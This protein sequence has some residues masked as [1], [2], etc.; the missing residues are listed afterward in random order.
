M[1]APAFTH[2]EEGTPESVWLT[3][4]GWDECRVTDAAELLEGHDKVVVASA[5]PDDETLAIG[6]LLADLARD[7]ASIHVI[8]ATDGEASHPD[9]TTWTS[10]ML[11]AARRREVESAVALLA[12][13]ARVTHLGL[14]DGRLREAGAVLC[15]RLAAELT[16]STLL[17]APWTDD[18]HP[19]HDAVGL[20][21]RE[22]ARA[23]G[24]TVHHYPVWLWHWA[25]P[26]SMPWRITL[27]VEPAPE[28]LHLKREALGLFAT[29][30]QPLSP[31]PGDEPV[32]TDAVLARASRLVE[33]LF[34]PARDAG[35]PEGSAAHESGSR[36]V[37]FDAMYA[38]STDPWSFEG[39][40]YEH[41]KRALTLAVLGRPQYDNVLEVGCATGELT[42]GLAVRAHQV[43]GLDTSARALAVAALNTPSGT[44]WLR[45]TAPEDLPEGPFDLIVLSE[46]GYFMTPTELLATL[47]GMRARLAEG[48][49][50]VLVHWQHPTEDIPLDGLLVHEQARRVLDLPLRAT[51]CD[52]DVRID[53]W[54][55]PLSIAEMEGRA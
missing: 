2:R 5:H 8:V 48:G 45:G 19:D 3:A 7:D 22:A 27:A 40:F 10:E 34:D 42:R 23:A 32:V 14:P 17:L 25:T 4:P 38:E 54:G 16:S 51:Y 49:E 50:I 52:V 24:C 29:Q 1:S 37:A 13:G 39:S 43:I 47:R 36:S 30:T 33:V 11:A 41:R 46:V 55:G 21:A 12:P 44:C 35:A 53:S 6:A 9:S 28:A 18:G 15:D 26:E 20:A 31:L